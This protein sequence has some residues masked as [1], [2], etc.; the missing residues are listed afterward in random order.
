[1]VPHALSTFALPLLLLPLAAFSQSVSFK[2]DTGICETTPNVRQFSGYIDLDNQK[3]DTFFFWFF[4]SRDEPDQKPLTLW[5]N[6]GPGCTSM[7]GL[8]EENGPC[9]VN[10][11]KE[12]TSLNPYSWTN[13][14]NMLY[15][16][17]PFGAGFSAGRKVRTNKEA[18]KYLWHGL[19][20]WF[21]DDA[22]SKYANRD[23]ILASESYG[24][25]FGPV[26]TSYFKSQNKKIA[27][28]KVKGVPINISKLII[29]N[30]KHDPMIQTN[31]T[32]T[33]A[34]DPPGYDPIV[35]NKTLIQ[36]TED[37]FEKECAPALSKCNDGGSDS[38]CNDAVKI[39]TRRVQLPMWGNR[40]PND[41]RIT[42]DGN[43]TSEI[44]DE[45]YDEQSAA[46]HYLKFL[47][48]NK[49]KVG[50]EG[51]SFDQCDS[52]VHARFSGSGDTGR[53]AINDLAEIVEAGEVDVMLWVGDAD[54]KANWVGVHE[55]VSQMAWSGNH[56]FADAQMESLKLDDQEVGQY[57]VIDGP[58]GITFVRVY[59]AG[60][61]MPQYQRKT[62]ATV[63]A[64]FIN[65]A[66]MGETDSSKVGKFRPSRNVASGA[67]NSAL[68]AGTNNLTAFVASFIVLLTFV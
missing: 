38:E 5:L 8:F 17:Q 24:A 25:H 62:A 68:P 13:H 23:F 66:D 33:F 19:Q 63:F 14:T 1:M 20:T 67:A 28:G 44:N 56:A 43:K 49:H 45:D 61:Q 11:D 22:F 65:G 4:E 60:H 6:G 37:A 31:A 10:D 29:G 40:D 21:A 18:A 50:A 58:P 34:I 59:Q 2:K 26:F 27:S 52:G 46:T 47:R 54:Q 35:T 16:D 15:I 48:D 3:N 39:C 42:D 64:R 53:S 30:G 12:S 32:I 41:L 9:L 36:E 7:I 55:V 51:K 57:K